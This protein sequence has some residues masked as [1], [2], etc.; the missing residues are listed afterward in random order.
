MGDKGGGHEIQV[1]RSNGECAVC[2]FAP[3]RASSCPVTTQSRR[4]VDPCPCL[5]GARTHSTRVVAST[6]LV[7]RSIMWNSRILHGK[8]MLGSGLGFDGK[9]THLLGS[10]DERAPIRFRCDVNRQQQCERSQFSGKRFFFSFNTRYIQTTA[11]IG[12][13]KLEK[14]R[15]MVSAVRWIGHE[16]VMCCRPPVTLK[17]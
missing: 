4:E 14:F 10:L 7:D 6:G 5:L 16:D 11:T 8:G 17:G 12:R 1:W 13:Q 15:F 3:S 9:S 2:T